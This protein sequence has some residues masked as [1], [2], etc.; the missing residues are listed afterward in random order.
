MTTT[1]K[2]KEQVKALTLEAIKQVEDEHPLNFKV[3]LA[4]QDIVYDNRKGVWKVYLYEEPAG[5]RSTQVALR[6]VD[7]E[8]KLE[9]LAGE[10]IFV[11]P[12]LWRPD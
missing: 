8:E 4:E 3:V 6:L 11:R 2:S 10:M 12:S 5:V 9:E 1:I 7:V